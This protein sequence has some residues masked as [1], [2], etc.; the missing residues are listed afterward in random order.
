MKEEKVN[1]KDA[2][3]KKNG[4][5]TDRKK[6]PERYEKGKPRRE[7]RRNQNMKTGAKRKLC[8]ASHGKWNRVTEQMLKE[9]KRLLAIEEFEKDE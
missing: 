9:W 5:D 7:A 1:G 3:R 4:K 6:N 2:D 8:D